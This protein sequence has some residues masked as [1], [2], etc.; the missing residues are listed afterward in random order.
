MKAVVCTRYGPPEVLEI[1]DVP[2]AVP[3]DNEILIRVRATTVTAGDWRIRSLQ[4]PAGFA[5]LARPIFGFSRP[6][7]PVLGF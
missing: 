3:G 4:M 2:K 5:L 1:H 7:Q 6:R